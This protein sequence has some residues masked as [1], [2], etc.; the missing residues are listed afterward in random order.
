[1][2][3]G[4]GT[5]MATPFSQIVVWIRQ[6]QQV[7]TGLAWRTEQ[8]AGKAAHKAQPPC[9]LQEVPAQYGISSRG[10]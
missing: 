1:M 2:P 4:L 9:G 10:L 6:Q 3:D 8:D 7:V 5:D